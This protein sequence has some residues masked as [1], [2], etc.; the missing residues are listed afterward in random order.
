M[1]KFEADPAL[2][3]D[4]AKLFLRETTELFGLLRAL[5]TNP[6]DAEHEDERAYAYKMWMEFFFRLKI[7][8]LLS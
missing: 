3:N 2:N 6:R 5:E 7:H 4:D 1:A 8:C